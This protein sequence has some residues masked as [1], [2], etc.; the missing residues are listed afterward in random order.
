M[1]KSSAPLQS[2]P[3]GSLAARK[4]LVFL[5]S[6]LKDLRDFPSGPKQDCGYQLDKVQHGQQPDNFK[7]ISTVGP[8]VEE[9]IVN[10][11]DGWF[12]VLYTARL[13]DAVYVLHAFQKKTNQTAPHDIELGKKR[14]KD[15]MVS[16]QRKG[17]K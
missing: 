15:L 13:D 3:Q 11:D 9:I 1:V 10:D 16:R 7:P 12:R 2:L 14:Y 6:S 5:G 4:S 8:G 17:K